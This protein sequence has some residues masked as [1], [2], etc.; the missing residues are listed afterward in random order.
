[1]RAFIALNFDENYKERIFTFSKN[2]LEKHFNK[3]RQIKMNNIHMTIHFLGSIDNNTDKLQFRM[4]KLLEGFYEFKLELTTWSYFN[5]KNGKL[6]WIKVE[7]NDKLNTIANAIRNEFS[8]IRNEDRTFLPH[9][10]VARDA[11][12]YKDN[13]IKAEEN[14]KLEIPIKKVSIMQSHFGNK[15]VYY[16]ELYNKNL[17]K[18]DF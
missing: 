6:V 10:T 8:D 9:I 16:S 13:N 1:M 14:I 3:Y 2:I 7:P 12:F 5:T 4:N 11:R 17:L 18:K 15:G